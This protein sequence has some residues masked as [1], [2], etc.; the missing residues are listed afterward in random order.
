MAGKTIAIGD[1]FTADE[2]EKARKLYEECAPGTFN[3]TVVREVVTPAMARIDAAT[4]QANDPR[5]I[6]YM[7]EF[8][9]GQSA[10]SP[11]P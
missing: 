3:G 5:Y 8:A 1:L 2:L 6:G 7:L 10:S 11:K 4:G 9:L